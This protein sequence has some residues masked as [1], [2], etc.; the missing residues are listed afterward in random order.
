MQIMAHL[1][2]TQ[3]DLSRMPP[4][5]ERGLASCLSCC[6]AKPQQHSVRWGGAPLPFEVLQ[7]D[8]V[9]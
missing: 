4:S 7:M 6:P 8:E 5:Q 2:P 3:G 9:E 1:R